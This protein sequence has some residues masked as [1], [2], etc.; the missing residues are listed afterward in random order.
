MIQH[1][2]YKTGTQFDSTS[3]NNDDIVFVE[4]TNSVYTHGTQFKFMTGSVP[5]ISTDISADASSDTKTASPKAVKTYVDNNAPT[6]M[7]ASGS[8]HKGGLVP[9]TPSTTGITKF[10][11]EDGSWQ[12]PAYPT[13]L[14]TPVSVVSGS[15]VTQVL[16]TNIHYVFG[17]VTSLTVTLGT[18][19]SD[20]VNEYSFEFDSD[21]TATT[22]SVPS[23]VLGIDA[24]SVD[25]NTHYEVNI[26]YN[27]TTNKY[28]GLMYGWGV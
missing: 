5:T 14:P 16:T 24:T 2:Y 10:L 28:Y 23:T 3:L 13:I 20:V 26:K 21:S 7:S 4:D 1:K 8:G 12:V 17:T 9:D 15:S 22:L 27:A 11:R 6:V 25:A 19:T 18:P